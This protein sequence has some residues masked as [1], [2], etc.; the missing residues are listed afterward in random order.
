MKPR[1]QSSDWFGFLYNDTISFLKIK[2]FR[3][4]RESGRGASVKCR[5]CRG[6]ENMSNSDPNLLLFDPEIE[7]TLRRARQVRCRIELENNLR[8]QTGNL[9]S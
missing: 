1:C 9:A 8:S 7:R 3:T 2:E 5:R 4:G 6:I